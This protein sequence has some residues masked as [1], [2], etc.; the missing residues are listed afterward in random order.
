VGLAPASRRCAVRLRK[1]AGRVRITGRLIDAVT[2][3][4]IWTDVFALQDEVAVAVVSA[5]QPKLLQTEI[6]L[7]M[8]RRPENLT[9]V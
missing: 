2:G 3:A 7:A 4:H 6:A 1:A 5:V 9:S 8:R